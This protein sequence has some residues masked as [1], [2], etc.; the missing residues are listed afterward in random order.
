MNIIPTAINSLSRVDLVGNESPKHILVTSTSSSF[1]SAE[2]KLWVWTGDILKPWTFDSL[3]NIILSKDKVSSLDNYILFEIGDYIKPYIQPNVLFDVSTLST[4]N[5]GVY[6]QY[7]LKLSSSG[8]VVGTQSEPTRFAT[9]GY[10]WNYEG[11]D[12]FS[13]NNGSFGMVT[14]D[15]PKY[16]SKFINYTSATINITGVSS[17][18]LMVDRVNATISSELLVCSKEQYLIVFLNKQGLWDTFTP[19][20]KVSISSKIERD[21]YNRSIRNPLNFNRETD[22]QMVQSNLNSKQ[23][24]VINTGALTPEMGEW[25]EQ[26]VYSPKV[27]LVQFKGDINPPLLSPIT[28]DTTLISADNTF[29]SVD[30]SISEYGTYGTFRQ[31]PVVVMDTDFNRKTRFNDKGKINYNIK[32]EES[33]YKINSTR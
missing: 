22:H 7:Q 10:N 24:Y 12:S 8:V 1:D 16:Y 9:L 6:Y 19:T 5:E 28:V 21:T 14:T 13:Y 33:T 17:S 20:G 29:I 30:S 23:T 11:E 25:V 32:F 15:V 18:V 27:Y 4:L 26:I 2:L 3:P 31:I